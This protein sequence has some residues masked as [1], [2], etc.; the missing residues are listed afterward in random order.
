[1]ISSLSGIW[2]PTEFGANALVDGAGVGWQVDLLDP[3]E[4][5]GTV[6]VCIAAVYRDGEPKFYGFE[7]SAVR[8]LFELLLSVPGVGAAT[9][10]EALRS[11]GAAG[12][13]TAVLTGD[14]ARIVKV[15]GIGA[16]GAKRI[17]GDLEIPPALVAALGSDSDASPSAAHG[18]DL[19]ET[20]VS[21]GWPAQAAAAAVIAARADSD[22]E[23][24]VLAAAMASLAS[25]GT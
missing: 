23:A 6:S 1:M 21:M 7:T 4:D 15:R 20:L 12:V 3:P 16:K 10:M 25:G 18:D 9:A 13:C 11:L 24:E 14:D 2:S 19:T 22:D 8:A 5:G 17:V